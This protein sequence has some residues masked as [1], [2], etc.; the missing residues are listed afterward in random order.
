M[1]T[2]RH[3]RPC[4]LP[5]LALGLL[6]GCTDTPV[7]PEVSGATVEHA[8]TTD[9]SQ[10]ASAVSL[11]FADLAIFFEFNS[12][13]DDLGVQVALDADDWSDIQIWNPARQK[14]LEIQAKQELKELGLTELRFES[15]EPS[16]QEVLDLFAPGEYRFAGRTVDREVLAGTATLSSALPP[17]PLFTPDDGDVVDAANTVIAWGAIAGVESYEVIVSNE[18]NGLAMTVELPASATSLPVP[19]VF[20]EP[21]TEYKAEVL[22]IFPNGNKTITEHT[23]TTMP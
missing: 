4:A 21:D 22:A 7:S 3:L 16:P 18:D 10:N 11:P 23:F 2:A 8:G 9:F 14:I 6:V 5:I 19:A 15:A 20:M 12:T 17:A 1:T 13:D